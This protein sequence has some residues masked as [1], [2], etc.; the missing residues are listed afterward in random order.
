MAMFLASALGHLGRLDE[1]S[2]AKK[3]LFRLN[4]DFYERRVRAQFPF[5][6]HAFE[7]RIFDGLNKAGLPT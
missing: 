7:D 1:A 6:S 5:A 2:A 4:P 3:A